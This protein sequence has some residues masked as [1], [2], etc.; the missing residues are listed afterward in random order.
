MSVQAARAEAPQHQPILLR[1]T[2]GSI[3]LLT[4]NRPGARN[5]LSEG[6]IAELHVA[7]DEIGGDKRIR[8]VVL[9]ANGPAFCAGHDLKELTARRSDADRGRA[10][11][12]QIMNACSAM[13]QAIVR[14]PKPVV[15]AVQGI[16]TA[17]GCQLVAS[18]DLAVAS[19]AAAFATPGVD[20]GLFCSTPMV[21]LSRNVPRKQAMEMLLTGEPVSAA[22]A[23]S[24]GLVNR[25]VSAGT[26]RDAAIALAE[27]V[28]LKSAYT[29]KL[30]KEAF[31]R[32][33]EMNLADAYRFAAEVMTENMMARDAEE[34]IGAFIE[35]RD[36]KWQ[37][38]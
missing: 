17:A 2:I 7:L 19:E 30:G 34:G 23:Q 11:F 21:A 35:K 5:S 38:K 9:A 6:L 18:C 3:A 36:P 20:I 13:M 10:Y 25:V 12:A 8:A 28:A 29:V 31:Y 27:K 22:T 15:A 14:L 1:E 24:I 26:E 33:A 32:Q 16:A 37:D 4:L